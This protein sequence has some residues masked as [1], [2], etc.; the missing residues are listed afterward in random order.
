MGSG[1]LDPVAERDAA[2]VLYRAAHLGV[3]WAGFADFHPFRMQVTGVRF[4]GGFAR[5]GRVDPADYT[6]SEPDPLHPHAIRG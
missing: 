2:G 5:A 3:F 1:R 4:I 6:A